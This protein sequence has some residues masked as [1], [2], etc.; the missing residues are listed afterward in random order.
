MRHLTYAV[1]AA[2]V[3]AFAAIHLSLSGQDSEIHASDRTL[4]HEETVCPASCPL[5]SVDSPAGRID[6]RCEVDRDYVNRS[7]SSCVGI[8]SYN[9][10]REVLCS[11]R[12]ELL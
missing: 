1:P 2:L 11:C 5:Y 4:A 10:M 12:P 8:E 7:L 6:V 3:I 9:N